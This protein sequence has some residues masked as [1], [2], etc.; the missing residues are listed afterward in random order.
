[1]F[2]ASLRHLQRRRGQNRMSVGATIA[3]RGRRGSPACSLGTQSCIAASSASRRV[4][5]DSTGSARKR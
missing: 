2:V 5:R 1:M 3:A 4:I